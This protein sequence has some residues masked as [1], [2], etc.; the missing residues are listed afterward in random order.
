M[1]STMRSNLSVGPPIEMLI[2]Q[3]DSL[4]AGERYEL[5]EDD[6]YLR[7]LRQAWEQEL[8]LAFAKLPRLPGK[9]RAMRL[10]D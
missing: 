8:K 9:S 5:D 2:Y 3:L 7:T 4:T 6:P 1:D 10:V